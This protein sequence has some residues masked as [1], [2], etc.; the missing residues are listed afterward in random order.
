MLSVY[1]GG[2]LTVSSRIILVDDHRILLDA[3]KNLIEPEFQVVG[4]FEDCQTLLEEA[5]ELRPDVIVLDIGM[6]GIDGITAGGELKKLLPKTKLIF[7]TTYDDMEMAADAFRLG[8]SGYVLKSSAAA[9]LVN[10]VREVLR[11]GYYASPIL[12]E[13]MTGSFVRAFKCMESPHQLTLRQKS[14]LRLLADGKTMTEA[15]RLLNISR[16]TVAFHKYTMMD[17]LNIR[18][19]AELILYANSHLHGI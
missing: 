3:I 19:T 13:G 8:A 17:Q 2:N 16:R 11:G 5:P 1:R 6:P 15:A 18:S 9:D 14:V 12:T 4:T 7:L 10:A